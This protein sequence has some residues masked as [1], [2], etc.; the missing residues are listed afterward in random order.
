[1]P[2]SPVRGTPDLYVEINLGSVARCIHAL[3]VNVPEVMRPELGTP[4]TAQPQAERP[5]RWADLSDGVW[6]R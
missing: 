3:G 5:K 6:G 1:M 4:L 2:E